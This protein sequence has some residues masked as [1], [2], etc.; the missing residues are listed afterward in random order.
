MS[1]PIALNIDIKSETVGKAIELIGKAGYVLYEPIR[2]KKKAFAEAKAKEI[3]AK[4]EIKITKIQKQALSRILATETLRQ[5]NINRLS[6]NALS[7]I[8]RSGKEVDLSTDIDWIKKFFSFS[9]DIS[10]EQ[11]QNLWSKILSG[12]LI[13]SGHFSYKTMSTLADM[14]KEE[15]DLFSR[16][17]SYVVIID[18]SRLVPLVFSDTSDDNKYNNG[19]FNFEELQFLVSIGLIHFDNFGGFGLTVTKKDFNIKCGNKFFVINTNEEKTTFGVGKVLLTKEG[20]EL[21]S[22]V[23][24]VPYPNLIETV[25]QKWITGNRTIKEL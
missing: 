23:S 4:S 2:I 13:N 7:D 19:A 21:F 24:V 11:M 12:Q 15:A 14:R 3:N 6:S 16:L 20:Q 5:E 8:A 10:N 9:Q 17:C 25:R 1:S 18:G 22:V